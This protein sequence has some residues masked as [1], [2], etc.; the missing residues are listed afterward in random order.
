MRKASKL[1]VQTASVAALTVLLSASAFADNRPPDGAWR[2][3]LRNGSNSRGESRDHNYRR[4]SRNNDN[5]RYRGESR[6]RARTES[7]RQYRNNDRARY[8]GRI[9]R[10]AHERGGY[11][12]WVDGA[13]YAFWVPEARWH[14]GWRVGVNINIG[15][16]YRDGLIYSDVYDDPYYNNDGYSNDGYGA[17]IVSGYVDRVDYRTGT[18]WLRD[19]RGGRAVTVDMRSVDRR[20]SRLD[21]RDLRRGDRVTISGT[22]LRGGLFGADRI[23][24][25]DSG[26]Y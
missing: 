1:A 10:F 25:I 11:R 9:S 2:G 5:N 14:N 24:A 19:D 23:D 21:T 16:V 6:D 7:N 3:D 13:P 4:D 18:L 22:W 15:G 20:Y 26:R 12:L 17:N 8:A